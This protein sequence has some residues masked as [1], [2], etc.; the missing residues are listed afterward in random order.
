QH[1]RLMTWFGDVPLLTKDIPIAEAQTLS[2]T[3][4]A[5]VL[6][7]ILKELDEIQS[8]LPVNTAYGEDDR[9]RITKGA[10]IALKARVLLYEGR[11]LETASTC[12]MLINTAENGTYSLFPSYE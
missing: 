11:W 5:E 6:A 4:R 2:R 1:F 8:A 7:F 3:P 10:A 12:E 9:G